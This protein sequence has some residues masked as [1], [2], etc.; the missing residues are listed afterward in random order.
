MDNDR[1]ITSI[2]K[3][4]LFARWYLIFSA[5]GIPMTSSYKLMHCLVPR[6]ADFSKLKRK[7]SIDW[8]KVNLPRSFPDHRSFNYHSLTCA[9]LFGA[10]QHIITLDSPAPADE[11]RDVI[12]SEECAAL[13]CWQIM[14]AAHAEN[15]ACE[16]R[17]HWTGHWFLTSLTTHNV[18][19]GCS[20]DIIGVLQNGKKKSEMII[21]YQE[22]M[23]INFN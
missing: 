22:M 8:L 9:R 17:R 18:L 1:L 13:G 10:N 15:G 20:A 3:T 14:Y 5:R 11:I 6:C 2:V 23:I 19:L 21:K 4:F 16:S 7:T 12:A